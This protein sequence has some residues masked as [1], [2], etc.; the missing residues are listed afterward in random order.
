MSNHGCRGW[1]CWTSYVY[2]NAWPTSLFFFPSSFLSRCRTQFWCV[3]TKSIHPSTCQCAWSQSSLL[4]ISNSVAYTRDV[5]REKN[6]KEDVSLRG[7]PH[8]DD[9]EM[10]EPS[11]R[12]WPSRNE[13][14]L[15]RSVMRNIPQHW[16]RKPPCAGTVWPRIV[17]YARLMSPAAVHFIHQY[18][19]LLLFL[20]KTPRPLGN[21]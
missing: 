15:S 1:K 3:F 2:Q 12:W 19:L 9:W 21:T 5:R 4:L 8:R 16:A 17:V 10:G 7:R 14:S 11:K 6:R 20:A 13:A 18:T